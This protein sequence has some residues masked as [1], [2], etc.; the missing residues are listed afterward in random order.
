[1]TEDG[2]SVRVTVAV[3]RPEYDPATRSAI[4]L[5][6]SSAATEHLE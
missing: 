1:M 6:V 4:L 3:P 5:S 2:A